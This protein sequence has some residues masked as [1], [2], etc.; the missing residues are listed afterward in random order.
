MTIHSDHR[1]LES[2]F[3][4]S[5]LEAPKR[6]QRM[7]LAVQRYDIKVVYQPG[8]EQL[9]ADML[10]RVPSERKPL[11]EMSKEQIFQTAIEDT[12]AKEVDSIDP[13]ECVNI[14]EPRIALIRRETATDQTLQQLLVTV[15]SGWPEHKHLLAP[16][17]K[18]YW[19]FR[20]VIPAHNDSLYKGDRMIIP[21][22]VQKNM[23]SRLH[24]SHQ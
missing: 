10:S 7:L 1:Q 13:Q 18:I 4:K 5:T 24:S 9:V 15:M 11:T 12:I 19:T 23:L 21:K 17:V 6:L 22:Q 14:G 3:K 16:D 20:D 2:I 8:S